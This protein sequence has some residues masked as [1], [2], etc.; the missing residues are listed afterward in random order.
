MS[1]PKLYKEST[2]GVYARLGCSLRRYCL[3][4][5]NDIERDLNNYDKSSQWDRLDPHIGF[6]KT[7]LHQMRSL[8]IVMYMLRI[9]DDTLSSNMIYDLMNPKDSTPQMDSVYQRY[10][11]LRYFKKDE[12]YIPDIS[13]HSKTNEE[14]ANNVNGK[15]KTEKNNYQSYEALSPE[16]KKNMLDRFVRFLFKYKLITEDSEYN[17]DTEAQ[18]FF[19]GWL[20]LIIKQGSVNIFEA[21]YKYIEE[22]NKPVIGDAIH[23]GYFRREK[24][25]HPIRYDNVP[26]SASGIVSALEDTTIAKGLLHELRRDDVAKIVDDIYNTYTDT[27]SETLTLGERFAIECM[28]RDSVDIK[29]DAKIDMQLLGYVFDTYSVR[30]GIKTYEAAIRGD[31]INIMMT[32]PEELKMLGDIVSEIKTYIGRIVGSKEQTTVES[33]KDPEPESPFPFRYEAP[34]PKPLKTIQLTDSETVDEWIANND[35]GQ[36]Y[37]MDQR[38]I[39]ATFSYIVKTLEKPLQVASRNMGHLMGLEIMNGGVYMGRGGVPVLLIMFVLPYLDTTQEVEDSEVL[40]YLVDIMRVYKILRGVQIRPI[41]KDPIKPLTIFTKRHPEDNERL[42]I[43]PASNKKG[44]IS[45]EKRY[46]NMDNSRLEPYQHFLNQEFKKCGGDIA[47]TEE[48]KSVYHSISLWLMPYKCKDTIERKFLRRFI[49]ILS[50]TTMMAP[51]T[52]DI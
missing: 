25:N 33:T 5:K 37:T 31:P 22:L 46:P 49:R 52:A 30:F 42:S 8:C 21:L 39:D 35:D 38:D 50:A 44:I 14:H 45:V 26:T 10:F 43:H 19:D 51:S 32:T 29:E 34:K 18:E 1:I 7:K 23:V 16:K 4:L 36:M 3:H 15:W 41:Y 40:E 2:V 47:E 9:L 6:A 20:R 13:Y 12:R 11:G 27:D 28:R 48:R 17:S 24:E